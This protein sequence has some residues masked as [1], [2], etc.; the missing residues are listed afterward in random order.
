MH[1]RNEAIDYRNKHGDDSWK[2]QSGYHQ[3]SLNEVVMFRYKTILT[4]ELDARKIENQKTEV[5]LKCAMLNKF[6]AIG[7]P[8]A[9]RVS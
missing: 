2:Q 1:Q 8:E 3:R 5:K 6:L 4:G 9:Y 7:M